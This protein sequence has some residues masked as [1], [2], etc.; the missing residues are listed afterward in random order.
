MSPAARLRPREYRL[1]R[2]EERRVLERRRVERPVYRLSPQEL[3]IVRKHALNTIESLSLLR[4]PAQIRFSLILLR[5]RIL[6]RMSPREQRVYGFAVAQIVRN[7]QL[8]QAV[9]LG[10]QNGGN[11]REAFSS[12]VS[13][14]INVIRLQQKPNPQVV[15]YARKLDYVR[16]VFNSY[17]F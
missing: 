14:F 5:S 9:V 1:T 2:P 6:P 8:R 13:N 16:R 12:A 11:F 10:I 4:D 3:N 15:S 17:E 7:P